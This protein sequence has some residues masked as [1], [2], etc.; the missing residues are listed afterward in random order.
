MADTTTPVTGTTPTPQDATQVNDLQI[1]L[2][3][4]PKEE[5]KSDNLQKS[6]DNN[7]QTSSVSDLDLSLD[8]NLPDAPKDDD[9]LKTEDQKNKETIIDPINKT[10]S[11]ENLSDR[12]GN[13][14]EV[15]TESTT[16]EGSLDKGRNEEGFV[17][18]V[19][20]PVP[21]TPEPTPEPTPEI[22]PETPIESTPVVVPEPIVEIIPETKET[23]IQSSEIL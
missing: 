15:A 10:V 4:A 22:V 8:L 11:T 5:N 23:S 16:T 12:R 21:T 9:R 2:A 1:N 6:S 19:E 13:E 3:E 20:V 18:K 7:P 17:A 14:G